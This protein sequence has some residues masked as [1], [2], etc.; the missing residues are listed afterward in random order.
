MAK[1]CFNC[2]SKLSK[3]EYGSSVHNYDTLAESRKNVAV[4]FADVSGFTALSEKMDPEEVRELI[5]DCFN[6]ITKPVYELEGTIDKY[7]GDCVMVLFG[8]KYIHSDDAKRAVM[9]AMRM[10]NLIKDFSQERLASKGFSLSLS[11]GINF[12]LVV[13]GSVGNYFDKDYTVMGDIVNIAQRLQSSA[14]KGTIL[15]S[16]SVYMETRDV[17]HYSEACD[18]VVKNKE[19]PV[20]CYHPI[21]LNAEYSFEQKISFVERE[22]EINLL[23]SIYNRALT[24]STQCVAVIGEAGIGKTRFLK[25]FVSQ[26]GNDIKKIWVDCSYASQSRVHYLI[27]SIIMSIMNIGSEDSINIKQHRLASFLDYI[28][29]SCS[30]EEIKRNY[31]FLGLLLGFN[32]DN[33][34]QNILNSM[35]FESI[36]REI[37]KQLSIFFVNLCKKHRL[38]V[39][40]DDMQWADSNSLQL[41]KEL[42]E[43]LPDINAIF[44]LSSRYEIR[45]AK[46]AEN[47]RYSV[48]RLRALSK[49]GTESLACKLL[50]CGSIDKTLLDA[51]NRFTKGNPLYTREFI[52]NIKRRGK[53]A[54]KAGVAYLDES[55]ITLLPNNIQNLILSNLSILDDRAKTI[56]QAASA[57]GKDFHLSLLAALL[58]FDMD[59]TVM[60]KMPIELNIIS[61]K[62]VY[63][64]RGMIEKIYTFNHDMEREVIYESILN[65]NKKEL[66][67]KIAEIIESRYEK[68]IESY[69]EVLSEHFCKAG[70]KKKAAEYYYKAALKL[71]NNFNFASSLDHYSKFLELT[72]ER[73]EYKGDSK[74]VYALRDIGY[75]NFVTANYDK[76]IEFLNRALDA[77]RMSQDIHTIRLM[78]AEVYKDKGMFD[79]ALALLNDIEPEI[80]QDDDIYGKLLQMK[81]SI[82]RITGNP[83]ALSYARKSEKAL[84]KVKDYYNLSETMKQVGII[85]FTKGEIDKALLYMN[86]SYKYAEKVD[87]LELMAK[88]SGDMG[89]IYHSTGMISKAMEAFERSMSISRKISY[90]KGYVAA[91]I[92]MSILHMDKGMFNKA[93]ALL[94]ESLEISRNIVSKLYECI[95]LTNLG[96]IMYEKGNF[97]DAEDCYDKSLEIAKSINVPI[98]EGVNYIGLAKLNMKLQKYEKVPWLLDAASR[99]FSEAGEIVYLCDCYIYKGLYELV[100]CNYDEAL[101]CCGMAIDTAE[102]CRNDKKKLKALRLKGN[103]YIHKGE[104]NKAMQLFE[105]AIVLAEKIE[106]DYEIAKGYFGKFKSLSMMNRYDEADACLKKAKDAIRRIDACRW[107]SIID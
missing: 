55:E 65:R 50:E 69:Y 31:D 44:I 78:I 25:E 94:K 16:E 92:N 83:E 5:N 41:F 87:N 90:L 82:L 48:I 6:Y 42:I 106:S 18:I 93:E 70:V 51:I 99:I 107:S 91:C 80:R 56:L 52:A 53:Y 43:D 24:N 15:V 3:F 26:I 76:A 32:R 68:D 4:I 85:Y 72:G 58:D 37:L 10:M 100:K 8:A 40:V 62:S 20:R 23:N 36:K 63:T 101:N 59:E 11:I 102:E 17:V 79:E 14:E 22:E 61:V 73:S 66:H 38:V 21:S 29:S 30:D 12:G 35:N 97:A 13:T 1:F 88:V 45:M 49:E 57:I 54:V 64:A 60:L 33:E 77:A 104:G 84:L 75:I 7:M 34:F 81:C 74:V 71:K 47:E 96:D 105:K 86:K 9:C 95:S 46:H 27:S 89:I 98:E 67:K 39:I 2:G 28:L 19:K 103:V